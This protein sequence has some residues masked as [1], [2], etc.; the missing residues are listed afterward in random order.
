MIGPESTPRPIYW[1]NNENFVLPQWVRDR[2]SPFVRTIDRQIVVTGR[3]ADIDAV[4]G[5]LARRE[6]AIGNGQTVTISLDAPNHRP[7]AMYLSD[8]FSENMDHPMMQRFNGLEVRLCDIEGD[9]SEAAVWAAIAAVFEEAAN[10]GRIVFAD[11]NLILGNPASGGSGGVS[12]GPLGNTGKLNNRFREPGEAYLNHW[13]FGSPDP[14]QE[15]SG[16]GIN[17]EKNGQRQVSQSGSETRVFILDTF[18]ADVS[19]YSQTE[20]NRAG[21][22]GIGQIRRH[23]PKEDASTVD[24]NLCMEVSCLPQ[25]VT[26][27]NKY[28]KDSP[29][30]NHGIFVAGLVNRVA[31]EVELHLVQILDNFGQGEVFTLTG[32]LCLL[33]NYALQNPAETALPLSNVVVNLSLSANF[34]E[35]K[36]VEL[37]VRESIN[38]IW[39][40]VKNSYDS[41]DVM[42]VL[43]NDMVHGFNYIPCVRLGIKILTGLGAV[44]V[45][46]AG[47]ESA[48][49]YGH[50]PM[51]IPA[52]Y[53]E[54]IGVAASNHNGELANFSN[55]GLVMAPGGGADDTESSITDINEVTA[56]GNDL[57]IYGMI[58]LVPTTEPKFESGLAFWWGTSFSA[59]LVSGLAALVQE[60]YRQVYGKGPQPAQVSELIIRNAQQ[61]VIDVQATLDAIRA[62][63]PAV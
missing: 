42:H 35:E 59:P 52:R 2:R 30:K 21:K 57:S 49:V 8:L 4:I 16:R 26:I 46:S 11:P 23:L 47:N 62:G 48:N 24:V 17:L 37:G 28:L 54:V 5:A 56:P 31:P 61:N 45:A 29:L 25:A 53:K 51:G 13:A 14:K 41:Q 63:V 39:E 10:Q 33:A 50:L 1:P 36:F 58:S 18:P 60:K 22:A 44:V 55:Q 9:E 43:L 3:P 12:G 40:Q 15:F 20:T 19:L 34:S 27:H 7:K 32:V 6:I 38:K